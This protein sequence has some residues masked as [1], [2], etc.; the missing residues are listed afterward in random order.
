MWNVEPLSSMRPSSRTLMLSGI[1][2]LG[3]ETS[4]LSSIVSVPT[5]PSGP[6][7]TGQL[8]GIQKVGYSHSVASGRARTQEPK[9]RSVTQANWGCLAPS[10]LVGSHDLKSSAKGGKNQFT[11]SRTGGFSGVV[12]G[13]AGSQARRTTGHWMRGG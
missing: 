9:G 8:F 6:R 13:Q 7:P 12:G 11:P 3:W 2:A 4:N 1:L 10:L 5:D